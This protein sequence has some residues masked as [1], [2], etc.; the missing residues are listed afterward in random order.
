[1]ATAEQ[2]R[3]LPEVRRYDKI[4]E[5]VTT[6][7]HKK[8]GL[9]Y[10]GATVVFFIIGGLE[11]MMMRI[12]LSVPNAKVMSPAAYNGLFTLH[13]T[14]MI[15][16]VVMP[17][18]IGFI[19][20]FMPLQI[21]ARDMA[22]PRLN[23]LTFWLLVFGGIIIYY[24]VAN[25]APPDAG[26]FAYAPL[27]EV[28]YT[29]RHNVDWWILG[30]L[31]TGFGTIATGI[32]IVVTVITERAPGMSM[33]RMPLFTWMSFVNG[34]LILY[35]IPSLTAAQI[36]LLFDRNLGTKF[37]V[38]AAGGDAVLWQHL[39]WWFGHPEVYI[40]VLPAFGMISEVIP[41]FSRKP[42]FGRVIVI[43]SGW[44]IALLSFGV[45]AHH[46]FAVGLGFPANLAF[47]AA[48]MA[49]AVPTGIKIFNWLFTMW[50]GTLRLTT[51]MLFAIAF[52]AQFTI[53]GITGVQFANVPIDWQLTDSYY[54]VGHFHY[55]L[56]GGTLFAILAATYYWFPKMFG[57]M[58]SEKL[59]RWNFWLMVIGFNVTFFPMHI[60]GLMGM[61]RR[62]HTYPNL[63][64]WGTLNFIETIGAF[65]M[66]TA[67]LILLINIVQ[68]ARS[69]EI[70][71]DNPWDAWTLEWA[72][73]SPPPDYNFATIPPVPIMDSRPLYRP[74][75][76]EQ[77]VAQGQAMQYPGAI[78]AHAIGEEIAPVVGPPARAS[79][80]F[81]SRAGTP[82]LGMIVLISSELIFFGS[83]IAAY[84]EFHARPTG[85]P[86]PK[87][88]DVLRTGLFSIALWASSITLI[89]GERFMERG[90]SRL[91]KGFVA[92]T[93][94]LGLIFMYGQIT[95]FLTMYSDGIKISTNVFTSSFYTLTGFH[96]AHVT[97]G[98]VMLT[99]LL[100]LT[101]TGRM[102]KGKHESAI[103]SISYYWHFVDLVWVVIFAIVYLNSLS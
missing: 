3:E 11:A 63:P 84:I 95:E 73:S 1:M 25:D 35:A 58:L 82:A 98:L 69:G 80:E 65:M 77:E 79:R 71:G 15:F 6:T 60:L 7:D 37:F 51:S 8:I 78:P 4:L 39:F 29:L 41:V 23:A 32:N 92:G 19:N 88:L 43:A 66:M 36:M 74:Q 53:G 99:A 44:M 28:P 13:G 24:S 102:G 75:A 55:V 34:F 76:R 33:R 45:W 46:M 38:P 57:R 101:L 48:S 87:D 61:P 96:G 54:V 90:K 27:T 17:M 81:F 59:G 14:T 31:V 70:A 12:Q 52:I 64:W 20:Y 56:F 103:K 85:G 100:G 97:V 49:I 10:L 93:I 21:G 26:W 30:L 2:A 68:S 50:G 67:T 89:I 16:L 86:T 62:V 83:L 72:T 94:V 47:G 18:L 5:W 42:L 91:F 22:F 9:L 40:M